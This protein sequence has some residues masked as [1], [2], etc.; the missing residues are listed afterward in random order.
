MGE[1]ISEEKLSQ[2]RKD[3]EREISTLLGSSVRFRA[4]IIEAKGLGQKVRLN[5]EF[6]PGLAAS[7]DDP[8]KLERKALESGPNKA[9]VLCI[10]LTKQDH[11]F[12]RALKI[13]ADESQGSG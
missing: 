3:L 2:L 6:D 7:E 8:D 1:N 9:D 11:K 4:L 12:L 5:L 13:S 10:R